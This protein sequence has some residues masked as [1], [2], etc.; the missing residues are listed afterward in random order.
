MTGFPALARHWALGTAAVL[1][2]GTLTPASAQETTLRFGTFVGPTS[3]LNTDIFEPW[4]AQIEEASGG[5]LAFEILSG[6]AAAKPTE[7]IDSVLAGIIDVGWSITS[8]NPGRFNA[9]GVSELPLLTLNPAEG[10]VGMAA[11]YDAGLLDGFDG[12]KVLGVGTAD[13]ARLHMAIDVTGLA[14]F[15]GTKIRAAGRVL[16]EMLER[17]G[18]TPV[19]MPITS[20]AESLA[21]NVIDGAAADWFSVESFRL[22]DSTKTHMDLELGAPAMYLVM[23]QAR[24]DQLP[25]DVKALFDTYSASAFAEFWGTRLTAESNRVR[26][27]VAQTE[28]HVLLEPTEAEQATWNAA[29]E[30]EI[31]AWTDST[32]NGQAVIDTYNAAVHAVREAQ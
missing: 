27:V 18:A 10:S 11:L 24:Y 22:I 29:A 15:E 28:G 7:V 19:G 21:K 9:A 1:T 2:I 23:N 6:G 13:V 12:V 26:D 30:A 4:L 16:S 8:Y 25:D 31:A 32:A 14:D 3:F 20:V 17:I 5:Q